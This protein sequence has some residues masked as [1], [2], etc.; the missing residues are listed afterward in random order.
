MFPGNVSG[1]LRKDGLSITLKELDI[2]VIKE[3]VGG[4]NGPINNSVSV[5]I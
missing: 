5:L 1:N 4:I 3:D 2:I